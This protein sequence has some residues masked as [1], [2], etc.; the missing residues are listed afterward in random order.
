VIS[1]RN[2]NPKWYEAEHQVP[3]HSANSSL[4]FPIPPFPEPVLD[5]VI[6]LLSRT[7]GSNSI[8]FGATLG[9]R[10]NRISE[11]GILNS[12]CLRRDKSELDAC[13][14]NEPYRP[15]ILSHDRNTLLED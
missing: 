5:L 9:I 10:V 6:S 1:I 12:C 7:F 11:M 15:F 2:F 13:I 4:L 3:L 8:G 14:R